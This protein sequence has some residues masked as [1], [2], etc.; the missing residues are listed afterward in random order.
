MGTKWVFSLVI[1][2]NDFVCVMWPK[3]FSGLSF[4]EQ[5]GLYMQIYLIIRNLSTATGNEI[6]SE[7]IRIEVE[8]YQEMKEIKTE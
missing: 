2:K 3:M 8:T 1:S 7:F 4:I 5:N 6:M